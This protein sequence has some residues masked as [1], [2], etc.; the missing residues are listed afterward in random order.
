M[1]HAVGNGQAF[2]VYL[3][4]HQLFGEAFQDEIEGV[5]KID[6]V[7]VPQRLLVGVNLFSKDETW[8]EFAL[9]EG[10]FFDLQGGL[11]EFLIFEELVDQ[12]PTWIEILVISLRF[13]GLNM[14]GQQGPAFDLH[15]SSSHDEEFSG[16]LQLE[17]LHFVKSGEVLVGDAL[18]GDVV[19]V[20]FV[21]PDQ[22]EQQVERAFKSG[23]LD[24]IAVAGDHVT[25]TFLQ[26]EVRKREAHSVRTL[27]F[28]SGVEID[29]VVHLP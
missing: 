23:D 10:Q 14:F 8:K 19:D 27:P 26:R 12:L 16:H 20:D 6:F 2:V 15:Q 9:D 11:F 4:D 1:F 3:A 7:D 25:E 21:F 13:C 29:L 18:D 17:F 28:G 5:P 24:R 22:E